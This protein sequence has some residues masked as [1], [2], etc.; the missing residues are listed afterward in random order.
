MNFLKVQEFIFFCCVSDMEQ[1]V[2]IVQKLLSLL[3]NKIAVC[4]IIVYAQC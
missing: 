1:L 4:S 3:D 2:T